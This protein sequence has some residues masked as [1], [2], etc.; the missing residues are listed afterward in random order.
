MS[1]SGRNVTRT[2]SSSSLGSIAPSVSEHLWFEAFTVRGSIALQVLPPVVVLV[3]W[4]TLVAYLNLSMTTDFRLPTTFITLLGVVL[5]LLLAFRS[6]QAYDR[7][8]EGRK[9]WGTLQGQ[10]RNGVRS[11]MLAYVDTEEGIAAR[12]KA[13]KLVI[14]FVFSL[15]HYLRAERDPSQLSDM[16][17]LMDVIPI[18]AFS[19]PSGTENGKYEVTE[20]DPLLGPYASIVFENGE[21]MPFKIVYVLAKHLQKSVHDNLLVGIY[22]STVQ[23]LPAA[24]TETGTTLERIATS[25]M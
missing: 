22:S 16:L 15:K 18:A 1:A 10:C 20:S 14:A 6:G 11:M 5:G 12:A 2:N 7:Y 13:V 8:S 25:P 19:S 9:T 17:D 23:G 3:L 24:F 21:G 4:T